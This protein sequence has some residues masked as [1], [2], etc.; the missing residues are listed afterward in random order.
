MN[1]RILG[2]AISVCVRD[3]EYPVRLAILDQISLTLYKGTV[4]DRMLHKVER[5][6]PNQ[7]AGCTL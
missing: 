3:R 7:R 2:G 5:K 6:H 1:P 4:M